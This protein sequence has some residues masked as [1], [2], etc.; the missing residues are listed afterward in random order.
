MNACKA[1]SLFQRCINRQ[2]DQYWLK[3][4]LTNVIYS[5]VFGLTGFTVVG[6]ALYFY[7]YS[8]WKGPSL[9]LED[10]YVMPDFRGI[11][12]KKNL[13]WPTSEM[14][15]QF[16]ILV[17]T[18]EFPFTGNGI[19]KGLL[20]K[21][22]EVRMCFLT[23]PLSFIFT[24]QCLTSLLFLLYWLKNHALCSDREKEA[25]C[26]AAAVCFGLEHCC[27]RLLQV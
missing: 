25:V 22:A 14:W 8:T 21:V 17:F 18:S 5:S 24:F 3:T 4:C 10:L 20:S 13:N 27:A 11:G 1:L 23:A 19:G 7:T 16:F 2:T 26:E 12:E 6:Y 9:Y 15:S